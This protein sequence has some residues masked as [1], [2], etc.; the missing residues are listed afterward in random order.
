MRISPGGSPTTTPASPTAATI[1]ERH[2]GHGAVVVA[3]LVPGSP[4]TA[5]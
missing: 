1:A 2:L 3:A 5:M 4:P